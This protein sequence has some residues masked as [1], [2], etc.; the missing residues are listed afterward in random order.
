MLVD[1]LTRNINGSLYISGLNVLDTLNS[2]STSLSILNNTTSQNQ[3]TLIILGTGLSTSYNLDQIMN[4][5]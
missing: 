2:Y 5:H 1:L 4:L 3:N